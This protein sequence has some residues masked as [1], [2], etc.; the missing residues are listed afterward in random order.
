MTLELTSNEKGNNVMNEQEK[1]S[2]KKQVYDWCKQLRKRML[3]GKTVETHCKE[4]EHYEAVLAAGWM[5]MDAVFKDG[6]RIQVLSVEN[7]PKNLVGVHVLSFSE[8]AKLNCR[9][10]CASVNL[11]A[12]AD[13]VIDDYIDNGLLAENEL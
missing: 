5:T 10:E 6:S 13:M 3:A 4:V 8:S 1:A 7:S 9:G 2:M 11:Y 12:D